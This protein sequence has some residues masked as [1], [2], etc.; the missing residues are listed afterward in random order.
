MAASRTTPR[1]VPLALIAAL[2]V[3]G[4]ACTSTAVSAPGG[5]AAGSIPAS[6]PATAP[7]PARSG[8][9]WPGPQPVPAALA[10]TELAA[11]PVAAAGS[12]AGYSRDK[13]PHWAAQGNSCDTREKV[14]ARDGVGV[15]AD[16]ACR[17]VAGTWFS[18]YDCED[19]VTAAAESFFASLKRE[20]MH[21][22]RWT[23]QHQARLEVFRWVSFYNL[24][25]RH[26]TLGYLS[27]IQFEQQT[28][29]A[30]RITLAA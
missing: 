9:T 14:L 26:S 19:W 8:G 3:A 6:V 21:G 4:T 18:V 13:F 22:A 16:S 1:A 7:G 23:S 24:R 29:A 2:A 11:L 25:R 30:R 5:G 17:A 10:R 28:A 15:R 12:M 27:P 20:L